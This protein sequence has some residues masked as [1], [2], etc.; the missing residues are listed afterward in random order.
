MTEF[1][2]KS[3]SLRMGLKG[4]NFTESREVFTVM[5]LCAGCQQKS[6]PLTLVILGESGS[7][8]SA[9]GNTILGEK[10]FTS[11]PSSM[12]VTTE[13]ETQTRSICGT[14]VTVIDTPDF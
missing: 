12:P 4:Q 14:E 8:K 2:I 1:Q 7:G 5:F 11:E 13:C 10:A 9:S 3:V 6:P